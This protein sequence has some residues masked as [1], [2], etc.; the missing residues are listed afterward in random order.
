MIW[1]GAGVSGRRGFRQG[2]QEPAGL[3]EE[4]FGQR[5]VRLDPVWPILDKSFIIAKK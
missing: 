2:G 4:G 5:P 1:K 3:R